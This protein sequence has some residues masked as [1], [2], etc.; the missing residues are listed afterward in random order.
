ML[1]ALC[2]CGVPGYFLWP[3]AQ[4]HPVSAVLPSHI[5]DLD[6]RQGAADQRATERLAEQAGGTN[7]VSS[8]DA[9]AGVY[10][11]DNGKRV[12]V[13]GA[14][15]LR[16][17]PESDVEAELAHLTDTYQIEDIR[18]FDLGETGVHE[19]CG[20]GRTRQGTVVVCAWADH[21]SMATVLLTRRSV[22][23]S[24]ELTGTLRE[25]ILVRG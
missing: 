2:C 13:F 5:A 18:A 15:G 25:A 14:T 3:A 23:E 4:Q 6:L 16:L 22:D 20:V 9:F 8:G 10:G 1:S 11:D 19:R 21:G 12:T 17:T 24:A 7:L